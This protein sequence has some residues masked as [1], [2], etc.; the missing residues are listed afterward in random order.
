[1]ENNQNYTLI[2]DISSSHNNGN[3]LNNIEHNDGHPDKLSI[4]FVLIASLSLFCLDIFSLINSYNYLTFYLLYKPNNSYNDC[5]ENK[6]IAEIF[7]TIFATLAAISA[8]FLSLGFLINN[9]F[10]MG[11]LFGIYVYYNYFIFGPILLCTSI[12][13]FINFK[14][15]G[16]SCEEKS[17]EISINLS[18]IICLIA[19][20][21]FGS[22]VTSGYSTVNMFEYIKDT[23]KFKSSCNYFLGKA[24]WKYA[25]SRNRNRNSHNIIF[26]ER[27]E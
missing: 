14:K 24:F 8:I 6:I 5:L 22:V 3:H 26:H 25:L 9:E 18:M 4:I 10:F 16:Y 1:M 13:G 19:I 17:D 12:F 11:K 7:F 15:I 27:N 21:T 2:N 20:L 23:I